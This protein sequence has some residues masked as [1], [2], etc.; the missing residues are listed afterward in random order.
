MVSITLDDRDPK[1][2]YSAGWTHAGRPADYARTTSRTTVAGSTAKLTFTGTS[3]SVFGTIPPNTRTVPTPP[4]SEY[5]IDGSANTVF[6]A[7]ETANFQRNQLF[8]QS[9][10][11]PNGTHALTITYP[12]VSDPL[13]LDFLVVTQ[14][15]PATTTSTG[16][17]STSTGASLTVASTKAASIT[18]RT[19]NTSKSNTAT[20]TARASTTGTGLKNNSIPANSTSTSNTLAPLTVTVTASSSPTPTPTMDMPTMNGG[21]TNGLTASAV[22]GGK[23]NSRAVV[24]GV[25]GAIVAVFLIGYGILLWHR[26]R[27]DKRKR[28]SLAGMNVR[29]SGIS[30]PRTQGPAYDAERGY[31]NSAL[32]QRSQL[33]RGSGNWGDFPRSVP[34]VAYSPDRNSARGSRAQFERASGNWVGRSVPAAMYAPERNSVY[35]PQSQYGSVGGSFGGGGGGFRGAP[36]PPVSNVSFAYDSSGAYRPRSSMRPG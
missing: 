33:G 31:R 3:I 26:R 11:L 5:S 14:P 4:S 9:A 16:L 8:F 34:T 35:N 10:S 20:T 36:S 24:G 13:F 7:T 23:I 1:I 2:V 21:T 27:Q 18:S 30:L 29:K 15:N 17:P 22:S 25:M 28:N 19:S 12:K 32:G 6:T